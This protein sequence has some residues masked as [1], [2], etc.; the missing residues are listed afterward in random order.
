MGL[1]RAQAIDR[2]DKITTADQLRELI[3]QLDTKGSPGTT[4]FWSGSAGEYGEGRKNKISARELAESL[5]KGNSGFRTLETTEAGKFLNFSRDS[6]FF[7]Q[8]LDNKLKNIFNNNQQLIDDFLYGTIDPQTKH[9]R[10]T[11][12]WDDVSRKFAEETKGDVRLIIGGAGAD[13]IFAQTE[14]K[15]LLNNPE[16][17]TIEGIPRTSLKLLESRENIDSVFRLLS[18]ISEVSTGMIRIGVDEKGR[19]AINL[20]GSYRIDPTDYINMRSSS[21]PSMQGMKQMID[22]IPKERKVKHIL[23]VKEVYK[24]HPV[25]RRQGYV[26][27]MSIEPFGVKAIISRIGNYGGYAS[28]VLSVGTMVHKS[29]MEMRSGNHEAAHD[30]VVSWAAETAVG[31]IAGRMAAALVAPLMM[32]GPIGFLVGAGIIIGA[33]ILGGEIGKKLVRRRKHIIEKVYVEIFIIGS[34]LV[35]D[36]DGS[37]IETLALDK[38]SIFFDHDN[39]GFI[40]KTGWAGPNEGLLVLDLNGNGIVDS[41]AELFGNNTALED[42]QLAAHGFA[43]LAMYDT[44]RDKRIDQNDA[45]WTKLRVWRDQNSNAQTDPGEWLTLEELKI[46]ALLLTHY[47]EE[48]TDQNGNLHLQH[49]FYELMDGKRLDMTDV[50][51]AKETINSIQTIYREVDEETEKLPNVPGMGIL[52]SLHQALMDPS[53][54]LLRPTLLQ[55]LNATHQQRIGLTEDLLFQWCDASNNP[56]STA[57]R[58]F[59][60]DDLK[61]ELKLAVFEKMVGDR[62]FT[63]EFVLAPNRAEVVRQVHQQMVLSLNMQLHHEIAVKPLLEFAVPV[64]S[65]EFGPLQ[66]DLTKSIQHLRSQFLN[67]PDPAFIPMIQWLLLHDEDNGQTLFSELKRLSASTNDILQRAMS[68]QQDHK[69]PWEWIQGTPGNDR[70]NGTPK[71]DFIEGGPLVDTLWG[72]EGD[73]TLFGGLGFDNYYGGNGGDT[74][75]ISQ[76]HQF[77]ANTIF[78]Q[79]S[80]VGGQPDRLI[81]W[82]FASHE[83]RPL[84]DGEHLEFYEQKTFSTT[85]HGAKR[86]PVVTI[87]KQTEQQNRIEEFH[88]SDGVTLSHQEIL[89]RI[90]PQGTA[91]DDVLTGVMTIPNTLQGLAG[92]DTL[93]GG[94][95]N[96]LLDGGE[97]HDTLIGNHGADTL[98]GGP[99]NDLL[100][101]GAGNDTYLFGPDSGHDQI[102]EL[103]KNFNNFSNIDVVRFFQFTP[104][105]IKRVMVIGRNVQISFGSNA[106]LL[107]MNQLDP[108]SRIENFSFANGQFWNH[109]MLMRNSRSPITRPDVNARPF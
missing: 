77:S 75:I 15:A 96:D 88:F 94:M 26:A 63:S 85:D 39:N 100:N 1:T 72:N 106:S 36:L 22:Y 3:Q 34:P 103:D 108:A 104:R 17:R 84:M 30:T 42:G 91:R 92:N 32:T 6:Q 10:P 97:G 25:L 69:E 48:L 20:D 64:E 51:F 23:A 87:Q 102:R 24:V 41:G 44:N 80:Y 40:E 14:L 8:Q 37:G 73:D 4:I 98:H 33:S 74:Y 47:D 56:F 5:Q 109:E 70:L 57:D 16:V 93:I 49:G 107:L 68:F 78:D 27:P 43:A 19:P 50:W 59:I 81:F 95:L 82:N 28:D 67:D 9:R 55:W 76:G 21:A 71:N 29:T 54:P 46:R 38:T 35:L 45:I 79:G 7:N 31:F 53:N 105:D 18:G 58:F 61:L 101:G 11:G 90:Q 2:L 65:E 66:L 13:R 86:V 60:N 12:I 62:I 89:R 99:G 52:P 83:L